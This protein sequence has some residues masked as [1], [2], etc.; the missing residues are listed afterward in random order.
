MLLLNL[1]AMFR[2][3]ALVSLMTM[4]VGSTA[5]SQAPTL[6]KFGPPQPVTLAGFDKIHCVSLPGGI[7]ICKYMSESNDGTFL[8]E[9]Q[10]KR[11]GKWPASA[12]FG[13]TSD[14]EVL[15]G[16]LDGD[17]QRELV[18]ANHDGMSNGMAIDYWTISIFS[19][20]EFRSF[21]A[22][23]M[24][25][26]QEYGSFGTFV[27][28]SGRVDI[29]TT[30]WLNGEDPKGR[31]VPGTYLAGQWWRYK[32]GELHVVP[33]RPVMARRFLY[34]F[35]DER[36]RTISNPHIP[37]TWF[38]DPKTE[39]LRADLLLAS[40]TN[41]VQAGV[42]QKVSLEPPTNPCRTVKMMFRPDGEN[43]VAYVYPEI[44][45]TKTS[46]RYIGDAVTGRIYPD[47]YMPS[48]PQAW[49]SGRQA[50]LATYEDSSQC[51]DVQ[52]LWIASSS[53]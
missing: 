37:Y 22:P 31:R 35:A 10:G 16:D 53:R 52:V 21:Q 29:F 17:G 15:L 8:V 9:R 3:A 38:L 34:S 2:F 48:Q 42:I 13:E 19:D 26:V 32:S 25:S 43:A 50:T 1:A 39:I 51:G 47:E 41:H 24:F 28:T 11:L 45:I 40:K 7:R 18:V 44:G 36:N 14:F 33:D 12:S 49:L 23:L 5:H 27:P 4:V 20:A 46:L 6:V 30:R